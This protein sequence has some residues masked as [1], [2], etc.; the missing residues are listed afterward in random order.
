[1]SLIV[2]VTK[3]KKIARWMQNKRTATD[4]KYILVSSV[5]WGS[6]LSNSKQQWAYFRNKIAAIQY[7]HESYLRPEM[8]SPLHTG[9][10]Y[11]L[12]KAFSSV[13]TKQ[14]L[15]FCRCIQEKDEMNL[16]L[17]CIAKLKN[18]LLGQCKRRER[19]MTVT[20]IGWVINY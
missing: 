7:V 17:N 18:W 9:T 3:N 16:D 10:R 15:R 2:C 12:L 13:Q 11:D 6:N 5:M 20:P 1:M 14:S 19:Q 4:A 8:K